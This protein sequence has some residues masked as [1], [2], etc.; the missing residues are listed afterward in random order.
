MPVVNHNPRVVTLPSSHPMHAGYDSGP[1][2]PEADLIIGAE[3]DVPW[4]PHFD[5]IRTGCKVAHIGEDP[6]Y[7]RYPM[8][9]FP[10]DL[11]IASRSADVY[12]ALHAALQKHLPKMASANRGAPQTGRRAPHGPRRQGGEGSAGRHRQDHARLSQPLHRQGV[13]RRR[14]DLQR[15]SALA[16]ALSARH[17]GDLLFARTRR[18]T[19]LGPRR[20]ASARSSQPRRS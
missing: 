17:A 1:L 7:Q 12:E 5:K 6:V 8:R 20:R 19:G 15:I 18:G 3:C 11:S 10:S 14:R 13:R 4:Y 9:S 16:R 2:V